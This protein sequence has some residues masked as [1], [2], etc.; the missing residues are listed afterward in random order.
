MQEL[1]KENEQLRLEVNQLKQKL[2]DLELMNGG[3]C[4]GACTFV[5]ILNCLLSLLVEQIPL[6]QVTIPQVKAERPLPCSDPHECSV[7]PTQPQDQSNP[8]PNQ[9]TPS[10]N[11]GGKSSPDA[12]NAQKSGA[13]NDKGKSKKQPAASGQST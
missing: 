13:K 12:G 2:I 5:V 9:V 6:P 11:N 7:Q 1:A 8:S 4:T 10:K 3:V